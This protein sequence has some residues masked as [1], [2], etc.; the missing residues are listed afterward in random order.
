[1]YLGREVIKEYDL[2]KI[3]IGTLGSHSALQILHG[4]KKEGF[5]TVLITKRDRIHVY[6]EFKHLVDNFIIVDKWSDICKD[7]VLS[8]LR[9]LNT[10][11]IPHGSYIEYV[12]LKCAEAL[13]LPIFGLRSIFRIEADQKM[14]MKFLENAGILTPRNYHFGEEIDGLVIVKLPGAKGGKGY[15]LART[16]NEVESKIKEL[17]EKGI[18]KSADDAL[19][20]EYVVGT[21]AYFHYFYS[22]ILD[23]VELL[24]MDIRYETNIDGLRRLP[25]QTIK[26]I[27]I[28]PSF[29]VIG[30]IPMVLRESMLTIVFE[31]GKKFVEASKKMLPPG[32]IGPFCLESIVKDDLSIYVFEFSGRIV[33]GTNL[34]LH[35]SPYSYLY[36]DEPMSMGR[37]I[38]RE[39]RMAIEQDSINKVVT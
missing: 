19:I 15:F 32:I 17:I 35:G 29:V 30:N 9:A 23:R 38:A 13:R 8:E 33:A 34:Y 11:L 2:D 6:R 1:M 18:I 36:W 24:G 26:S 22:P 25:I 31:Y 39:I 28:V 21:P 14:K 27:D 16:R 20:Q 7:E 10:I 3:A 37:R 12:G 4:A 5:Y